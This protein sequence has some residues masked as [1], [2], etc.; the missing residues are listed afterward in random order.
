MQY[1]KVGVAATIM[2]GP[3]VDK[4]DGVTLKTD[5]T[6][7]TDID[8]ATTGIFLSKNG[9]AAA[10]RSQAVT[11]SVADAYGMMKVTLSITDTGTVGTLDVLFAKAAT[12]LPVHK[13]FMVLPAL[14]YDSLVGGTDN[15][16]VD[17]IQW[18]GVA[19]LAL[20]SQQIQA[21]VPTT[22]KVDVETIKTQAV[23]C[24]AGVTVLASVGTAVTATA[25][26]GDS[27]AI[28][29]GA[30]GLVNIKAD[31]TAILV[32]TGT[33]LDGR[34]PAALTANGNM[35][36]SVM[37]FL[38]TALTETAGLITAAFKQFFNVATPTGTLNV[39]PRVTLTDT[40]TTYTGNTLQTGD[41]A[42][43]IATVGVAGAGLTALG[44]TRIANLDAT[45]S[46]RTKPADTQAAVTTVTNLTNAPT[47]GDLTATMKS[48]VTAAVPTAAAIGTDAASKVLVTPAQKI[49]TNGSGQVDVNVQSI[50]DTALTGNGSALT[51]WGPV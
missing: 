40:V 38:A 7:I 45:V 5:A 12:Y 15:L 9:A 48:S 46:S 1:L 26:T 37:E 23:T 18:I 2:F 43:L 35:K 3:F 28:V 36:S 42:N 34:I 49:V 47:A 32:D 11:A 8:H 16:Q 29:N 30:S 41:V 14:V 21:V 22:S 31:T 13:C 25:Q 27:Y 44:D 17:T 4:T 10:I 39:I 50:N 51:P 33:T 19:P 6:T 24:G 20:S